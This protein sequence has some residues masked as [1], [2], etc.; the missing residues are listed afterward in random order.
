MKALS[1][2]LAC[3]CAIGVVTF[4]VM[5]RTGVASGADSYGYVSEA[6]LWIK[7]NLHISQEW[8]RELPWPKAAATV[9]PLGYRE[10]PGDEVAA[11]VPVYSPGLA[12]LMAGAKL[13]GGHAAVFWVVP[14]LGGLFVLSVYGIGRHIGGPVVGLSASVLTA[15]SPVVLFMVLWPMTDVAVAGVWSAACWAAL[16]STRKRAGIAGLIAAAALLIR[17]NLVAVGMMLGLWMILRDVRR[18]DTP[19]WRVDRAMAFAAGVAPGLIAVMLFNRALYGSPFVSGY[20]TL[21][22]VLHLRN[23]IPNVQRYSEWLFTSETPLVALGLVALFLPIARVWRDAN[24]AF[25]VLLLA[26]IAVGTLSC[27]LF[28]MPLDEWW[29]LRFLMPM[30]PGMLVG[31]SWLL[32]A[33]VGIARTMMAIGVVAALGWHGVNFAQEKRITAASEGERRFVT[34]ARLVREHTPPN[35]VIFSLVHSGS[36]RYYGERMTMRYDWLKPEWLDRGV[37]WLNERGAHPYLLVEDWELDRWK[38]DFGPLSPLG[39]M[40]M[41]VVFELQWPTHMWLFD[42]TKPKEPTWPF[43]NAFYLPRVERTPLPAPAPV[44]SLTPPAR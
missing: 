22:S 37:A 3:L 24:R 2:F 40:D 31:L 41:K 34:A 36:V 25:D 39:R 21:G 12:I 1:A 32:F 16:G 42:M 44:F 28:F 43:I 5:Y 14:L 26:M 27:Y 6:D 29:Y 35:S 11:I 30:W 19:W 33:R 17:P 15:L 8:A 10:Q 20:G 13:V 23:F 9:S 18:R 7:G 38:Q 4:G